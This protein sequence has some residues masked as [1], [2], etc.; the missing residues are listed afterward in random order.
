M[1]TTVRVKVGEQWHDLTYNP[2]TA[3]YEAEIAAPD[4][5]SWHEPG[6]HYS[7]A[8][9]ASN[10]TGFSAEAT[11]DSM[12]GL[13][14]RV[15]EVTPPEM[16]LV[17]PPEG[18]ITN[19]QPE[20]VLTATDD[21]SGLNLESLDIRLD[22]TPDMA[23][24][25][26]THIENGIQVVYVPT[27]PFSEGIHHLLADISDNDGNAAELALEYIIDTTPPVLSGE[28]WDGR[29]IVDT[30]SISLAGRATDLSGAQV[31]VTV[32]G[33][34]T[35]AVTVAA[36]GRF[37]HEIPLEVGE[38]DIV[39]TA[40]DIAGLTDVKTFWVM[41]LITDRTGSDLS[42]LQTLL[43]AVQNGTATEEQ[44]AEY[45]RARHRGAYNY[46]DMN[47]VTTAAEY[48]DRHFSKAGYLSGFTS[49]APPHGGKWQAEDIPTA[50]QANRYL[51]NVRGISGLFDPTPNTPDL[52]PDMEN[53][54]YGTANDIEKA[55]VL[56]DAVI[57][58][59]KKS[60]FYSNEIYSGEV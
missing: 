35:E 3:R 10:D 27:V 52:P 47:R 2:A 55:L 30:E 44:R 56:I 6:H 51:E 20:I 60:L 17:S 33:K 37:N 9:E 48:L 22:G 13:L 28:V 31:S 45:L 5:T 11:G 36:D 46:T 39:V 1:L 38:N 41:R 57:P 53:L 43:T 24:A 19:S 50:S 21:G 58:L 18:L 23:G 26:V 16:E 25:T 14:W 8:V 4:N 32:N 34:D 40:V 42:S 12:P 29:A 7:L 54:T 59:M 15:L 49:V